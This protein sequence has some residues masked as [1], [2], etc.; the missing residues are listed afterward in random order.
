MRALCFSSD[1][2]VRIASQCE[3]MILVWPSN[4]V[5]SSRHVDSEEL[6]ILPQF[7]LRSSAFSCGAFSQPS[8]TANAVKRGEVQWTIQIRAVLQ[9]NFARVR[10]MLDWFVNAQYN[11]AQT[12]IHHNRA[13]DDR[14]SAAAISS[15]FFPKRAYLRSSAPTTGALPNRQS[16]ELKPR[17]TSR[18]YTAETRSNRQKMHGGALTVSAGLP[19]IAGFTLHGEPRV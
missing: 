14:P 13:A 12:A 4:A 16:S 15:S 18:K 7:Y 2:L 3:K 6:F 9:V 19:I 11:S 10:T 8:V 17:V 5:K 1:E